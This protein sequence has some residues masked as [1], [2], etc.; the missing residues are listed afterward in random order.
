MDLT[1]RFS[2]P[3][4]ID[5]AWN[6]FNDVDALAPCFPGAA[7]SSF[8]GN[9]FSGSIKIKLGPIALVYNGS[10][11]YV[12][13][14]VHANRVVFEARGEDRRGNGEAVARVTIQLRESGDDTDVEVTTALELTGRPAQFGD[15]VVSDVSDRLLEQ[16]VSCVGPRFAE[17]LGVVPEGAATDEPDF[18]HDVEET[19]ELGAVPEEIDGIS[20]GVGSGRPTATTPAPTPPPSWS[21]PRSG[22]PAYTPPSDTSQTDFNVVA[23]VVPVLVKRYW[24]VLA[25]LA[26]VAFVLSKIIGRKR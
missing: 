15:G 16:F 23:T 24:P 7:I 13:R 6:A 14:N 1:H 19:I 8:D 3:A 10:G 25:A 11:H 2:V 20:L 9:A 5:E 18:D 22:P 4:G 26:V 21:P 17:G 12:E